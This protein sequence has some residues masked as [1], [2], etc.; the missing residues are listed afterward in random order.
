MKKSFLNY[1]KPLL[2]CMIKHTQAPKEC[3]EEIARAHSAGA[4]AFGI[5]FEGMPRKYHK[6]EIIGEIIAA[7]GDK[8]LYATNYRHSCNAE[9]SYAEVI[10]ELVEFAEQGAALCDI[11]G[12]SFCKAPDE[13]T[14][15]PAAVEKQLQAIERLHSKG[16]E[17]IMSSHVNRFI[18]AERVLEIA[19]E[20]KRRGADISKIVTHGNTMAEQLENLA[21]TDMLREKLGIPFLYL[22]GGESCRIHR[23]IGILLGCCMS[24]CVC[25]DNPENPQPYIYDQR[26]IRDNMKFDV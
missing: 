6:P 4:E 8:P 13:L 14:D 10:D 5:Q 2:T 11:A 3:I 26:N 25:D 22:S 15:D 1:E 17:V 24:L 19:A 20:H 9:L 7:T 16:A 12:D 18:S 21:I 23:R